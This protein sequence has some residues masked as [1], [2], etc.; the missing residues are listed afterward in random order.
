M[1]FGGLVVKV[2]AM[3]NRGMTSLD[4]KFIHKRIPITLSHMAGIGE[5][6]HLE[7]PTVKTWSKHM[8]VSPYTKPKP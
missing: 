5:N 6:I 3:N 8:L 7:F 4:L 2:P 1:C